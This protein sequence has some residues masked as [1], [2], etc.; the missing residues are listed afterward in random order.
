M[1]GLVS[2][3]TASLL[4]PGFL[5]LAVLHLLWFP[6]RS[7]M[8]SLLFSTVSC[9]PWGSHTQCL[10]ACV[11]WFS[12]AFLM[13][14]LGSTKSSSHILLPPAFSPAD[15]WAVCSRAWWLHTALKLGSGMGFLPPPPHPHRHFPALQL[16]WFPSVTG[17]SG[18]TVSSSAEPSAMLKDQT[19]CWPGE[20][21]GCGFG[22]SGLHAYFPFF[23]ETWHATHAHLIF[24][25]TLLGAFSLLCSKC[26]CSS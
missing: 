10:Q 2:F 5:Q 26:V 11:A 1:C 7:Q 13:G 18:A 15:P 20:L 16:L 9:T 25:K 24:W 19:L 22:E 6:W 14:S 21:R 4:V 12:I 23:S 3:L 8:L 17:P